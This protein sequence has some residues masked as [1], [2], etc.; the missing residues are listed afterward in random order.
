VPSRRSPTI[1]RLNA[2]FNTRDV[3]GWMAHVT[4]DFEIE[5]RFASV[6]GAIFRGSAGVLAW[7]KDLAEAWEWMEIDFHDSADV[8]TDRTVIVG[9]LRGV[10]RE[11]GLRLDEPVAQRWYWREDRLAK[12]DYLDRRE[13]E[14]I[15]RGG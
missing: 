12:I 7:W 9:T 15:V 1:Q 8:G 4:E 14:M 13:A 6:A 10:G 5:S 3:E 11:S 2:A